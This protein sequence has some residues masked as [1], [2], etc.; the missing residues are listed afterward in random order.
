MKPTQFVA[1]AV[2][3][4]LALAAAT[5]AASASP[6]HSAPYGADVTSI[7]SLNAATDDRV[8][9][10][11]AVPPADSTSKETTI[12]GY[13]T[14]KNP[15]KALELA[16]SVYRTNYGALPGFP[17]AITADNLEEIEA[18]ILEDGFESESALALLEFID[19]YENDNANSAISALIADGDVAG[20][21]VS[22][23]EAIGK[24]DY[25]QPV[26]PAGANGKNG[27]ASTQAS[28]N[29][30]NAAAYAA[31]WATGYNT[32]Y[33]RYKLDCTNFVSQAAHAGGLAYNNN[34]YHRR[35]GKDLMA[36]QTSRSWRVAHDFVKQWGQRFR[37]RSFVSVSSRVEPGNVVAVDF[38]G[39]GGWDHL[40][41]VTARSRS[42][43]GKIGYYDFKV[44]QHTNNYNRWVS[45]SK[46][47]WENTHMKG[48]Y[49][50]VAF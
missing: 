4:L 37:S 40:G 2:A 50:I 11:I 3:A 6:S 22:A 44:A 36:H 13:S 25:I 42:K 5:P 38:A 32:N 14:L 45:D 20:A 27:A 21:L 49:A 9:H 17:S 33:P 26:E 30:S 1:S 10:T 48:W 34:W 16:N 12:Q 29:G 39:D 46:N 31:K 41:M 19:L 7:D 23:P 35:Y 8:P 47:G 18:L 43:T 28:Y 15:E 24:A